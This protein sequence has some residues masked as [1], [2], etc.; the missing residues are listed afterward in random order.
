MPSCIV[1]VVDRLCSGSGQTAALF[2]VAC[3]ASLFL[4]IGMAG[5]VFWE[6]ALRHPLFLLAIFLMDQKLQ[7]AATSKTMETVKGWTNR[8]RLA[9]IR[10][11]THPPWSVRLRR[12]SR[13]VK[14]SISLT[15]RL[16]VH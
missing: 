12:S 2:G 11:P 14:G 8:D 6:P 10:P 4:V 3:P 7:Q 15:F 16:Q 9:K 5:G 13:A 1:G